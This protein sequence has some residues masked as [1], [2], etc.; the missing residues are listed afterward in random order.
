M[1]VR[2]N[3]LSQTEIEQLHAMTLRVLEDVGVIMVDDYACEVFRKNGAKVDGHRVY[4]SEELL[5]KALATVPEK[6]SINGRNG[7]SVIIGGDHRVIAPVSGPLFVR[8]GN[9]QQRNTAEDYKNFQKMHHTS[10]VMDM[11]NPNLI[12]P[13]D[14][15]RSLVR[16]YQLAVCLKYTDKPLIGFTTSP[17][18]TINSI[19]MIQK[20]Y[21]TKENVAL[22]IISV[23][24]PL[25]Y[26]ETMLEAVKLCAERGQPMMFACCSMPG[27]TSP[28]TLSGTVVVNN[29]E[30]LAGIVYSQLLK[31]GI[32]VLY[33]NTTGGCDL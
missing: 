24:S 7:K 29:A 22:G 3:F 16:D 15:D 19:E 18:D 4:I 27:A 23:I 31:P 17:R 2:G 6:F 30:V 10:R 1:R 32:P 33:G 20:F 26:D 14:I 12:E 21:G 11:L 8:R 5:K 9:E 13:S 28:V 25:K